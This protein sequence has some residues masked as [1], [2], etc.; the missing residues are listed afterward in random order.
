MPCKICHCNH[1]SL[2]RVFQSNA[3][4]SSKLLKRDPEALRETVQDM[5]DSKGGG[6]VYISAQAF[7]E[8]I[9][10][11]G[12]EDKVK[13][14]A[15]KLPSVAPQ[16]QEALSTGADLKIPTGELVTALAGSGLE[17]SFLQHIRHDPEGLSPAEAA[18]LQ[19]GDGAGLRAEAE[20]VFAAKQEESA[21]QRSADQVQQN[22]TDQLEAT[23][24][25]TPQVN[26]AYGA[27]VREFYATQAKKLGV[28]AEA[29]YA[30]APLTIRGDA[31]TEA[32]YAQG[33]KHFPRDAANFT[34]RFDAIE[35]GQVPPDQYATIGR[36]FRVLREL[37]FANR[38]VQLLSGKITKARREHP[39]VPRAVWSNL[40]K[41]LADPLA[42]LPQ[43]RQ[44]KHWL[45]VLDAKDQRGWQIVLP[46]ERDATPAS[47]VRKDTVHLA[48]TLY[49]FEQAK[50]GQNIT[51]YVQTL[52]R[53]ARENGL[54]IYLREEGVFAGTASPKWGSP[55]G[56]PAL[57]ATESGPSAQQERLGK[58]IMT[59][60]GIV[61]QF[62][63]IFH[64]KDAQIG[65]TRGFFNPNM[66]TIALL[67][68]ADLST[69][70]HESG[71]FFL[72]TYAHLA[73]QDSAPIEI[74]ADFQKLLDWFGVK[75]SSAWH[76]LSIEQQRAHHERFARGFEAYL[77]EGKAPNLD[78]QSL[79]QLRLAAVLQFVTL[80][81]ALLRIRILTFFTG[82]N[83]YLTAWRKRSMTAPCGDGKRPAPSPIGSASAFWN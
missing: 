36:G 12:S 57:P 11:A 30:Q 5:A 68:D 50:S 4:A 39:E 73:R 26:Q 77:F 23:G 54:K 27:L 61:K 69:F 65:A 62:G 15:D 51:E 14:I 80:D 49:G 20:R 41:L 37:G 35:A 13:A 10:A 8:A 40:T 22:I 6:E 1:G 2:Q 64:Q 7:A 25:F 17:E 83:I 82:G 67:K 79:F 76:A 33:V 31:S 42:I 81:L 47:G 28:T 9:D 52:R 24:R 66:R 53:T 60:A 72:D 59:K 48:R 46:I 21:F 75:D 70:L 34:K 74:K 16:F 78:L 32:G 19:A 43:D 63:D 18:Q 45:V 3:A 29:L 38:Q 44:G 71:H 58:N 56:H 55:E